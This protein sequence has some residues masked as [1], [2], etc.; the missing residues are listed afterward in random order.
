M[1]RES[2]D[3]EARSAALL[4]DG[5][6][7]VTLH[8]RDEAGVRLDSLG[9]VA[10]PARLRLYAG[11][12]GLQAGVATEEESWKLRSTVVG[13]PRAGQLAG[14]VLGSSGFAWT[15]DL[16]LA[17]ED[18][19]RGPTP[20]D[21]F[22]ITSI[23]PNPTTGATTVV[24]GTGREGRHVVEVF[25]V[26]GRLV[27]ATDVMADRPKLV[28]VRIDLAGQGPGVYAVRVRHDESGTAVT[29]TLTV[30]R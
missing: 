25:D 11:P 1:V 18:D 2:L 26:L 20:P 17:T 23:A 13:W 15:R 3:P 5:K 4:V 12:V 8:V 22:A 19:V 16:R 27:S 6:G 24:I 9:V 7:R 29:R 28:P 21:A 30:A 14:L 10:L